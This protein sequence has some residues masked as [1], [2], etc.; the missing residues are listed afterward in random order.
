MAFEYDCAF[1]KRHFKINSKFDVGEKTGCPECVL[2]E[3]GK[4]SKYHETNTTKNAGKPEGFRYPDDKAKYKY[5][6]D[7]NKKKWVDKDGKERPVSVEP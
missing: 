7:P 2:G 4:Q 5:N 1:C 6:W 3:E